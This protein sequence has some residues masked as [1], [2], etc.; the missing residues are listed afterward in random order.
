MDTVEC[1][2]LRKLTHNLILLIFSAASHVSLAHVYF[3][4]VGCVLVPGECT[5]FPFCNSLSSYSLGSWFIILQILTLNVTLWESSLLIT[6][7]W[8][9][10]PRQSKEISKFKACL[11]Q[12]PRSSGEAITSLLSFAHPS[13]S[14]RV[15][16]LSC[17]LREKWDGTAWEILGGRE[18]KKIMSP[19]M[20][21]K[22]HIV[23]NLSLK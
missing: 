16:V 11:L 21:I 19:G 13:S 12:A 22:F 6:A 1:E 14:Y 5:G 17:L 18:T 9:P 4:A 10:S 7:K 8:V 23:L 2:K 20:E 15:R 3:S